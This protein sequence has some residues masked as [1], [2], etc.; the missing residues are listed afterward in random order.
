MPVSPASIPVTT[1]RVRSRNVVLVTV[2]GWLAFHV[3]RETRP[4][5]I[6]TYQRV[7]SVGDR[8]IAVGWAPAVN[9]CWN[10]TTAAVPVSGRAGAT[11]PG[12][13]GRAFR[14]TWAP[15]GPTTAMPSRRGSQR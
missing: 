5:L 10:E 15:A 4:P 2:V 3:K 6:A 7:G 9:I 14:P 13:D 12:F 1:R 8:T 11:H